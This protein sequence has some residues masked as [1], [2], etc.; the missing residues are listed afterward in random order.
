MDLENSKFFVGKALKSVKICSLR[1]V[2][3]LHHYFHWNKK[4][5]IHEHHSKQRKYND[6]QRNDES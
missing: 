2:L 1:T 4:P 6:K 3:C 5:I